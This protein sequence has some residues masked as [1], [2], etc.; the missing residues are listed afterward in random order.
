MNN[1]QTRPSIAYLGI[2]IVLAIAVGWLLVA[3]H[4]HQSVL[5]VQK[6]SQLLQLVAVNGAAL[7]RGAWW[8][9]LASQFV[10]VHFMHM[11]F[12]LCG[13]LV[14]AVAIERAAGSVAL[15][16]TYFIGGAVG[17][18][19]SVLLN[20]ELVSSG[21]SQAMIALCAFALL[22]YRRF[23][24]ARHAVLLAGVLVAIQFALDIYV[25]GGIKPGHSFG[26]AAGLAIVLAMMAAGRRGEGNE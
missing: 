21:A 8:R 22:G 25:S 19:F 11:L 18:Y 5:A 12:N 16:L 13:V 7:E 3:M 4:L 17:Q 2:A 15:A 14:L 1:L 26:F 9:L 24:I 10:H 20:P 23:A 6:S